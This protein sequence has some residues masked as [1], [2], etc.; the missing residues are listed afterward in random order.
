VVPVL[1]KPM[2][3]ANVNGLVFVN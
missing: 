1:A 2:P 3:I